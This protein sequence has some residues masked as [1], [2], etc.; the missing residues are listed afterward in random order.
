MTLKQIRQQ[1]RFISGRHDL[2][3][4]DGSDNGADFFI[5]AGQRYLDKKFKLSKELGITY[6][7]LAADDYYFSFLHARAVKEV[8]IAKSD[9]RWELDKESLQFLM[10]KYNEA[11]EDITSGDPAWYAPMTIKRVPNDATFVETATPGTGTPAGETV[12]AGFTKYVH[13]LAADKWGYNAV[14]IFP[15][16]DEAMLIEVHGMFK[17]EELSGDSDTSFWSDQHSNLLVYAACRELEISMRNSQG[18]RDWE[19]AINETGFGLDKD[20][21]EEEIADITQIEG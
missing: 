7:A 8:W 16:P 9:Q 2:V 18:R 3:N 11:P 6:G 14:M 21:V 12:L 17:A 10:T 1:F 4:A 5:N 20:T 19:E 13:V 15:P